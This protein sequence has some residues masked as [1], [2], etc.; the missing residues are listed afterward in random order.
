LP[1]TSSPLA[2]LDQSA[3]D[4]AFGIGKAPDEQ[5]G[6]VDAEQP[7][8]SADDTFSPTTSQSLALFAQSFDVKEDTSSPSAAAP[9]VS[10]HDWP[11]EETMDTTEQPVV[12]DADFWAAS[13]D[14]VCEEPALPSPAD[15]HASPT[16]VQ[17]GLALFAQPLEKQQAT[18]K[19]ENAESK[20]NDVDDE[21]EDGEMD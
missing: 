14:D 15:G 4:N 9:A 18:E 13:I 20:P 6:A 10:A 2:P 11:V 16:G 7:A 3:V 21:Q 19:T 12:I 1:A 17:A 8:P 5:L